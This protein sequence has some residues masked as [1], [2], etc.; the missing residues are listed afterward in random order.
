MTGWPGWGVTAAGAVL[1]L[2]ALRDIFHT[3]WHPSGRGGLSRRLMR[4]VWRAGRGRVPGPLTGPVAMVVVV[5]AW[6]TLITGGWALVYWPHLPAGFAFGSG[7]DPGPRAGA[8]DALYL[9]AVT[10]ATLGFGDIV[11]EAAWLRLVVPVQAMIGFALITAAVSWVLQV[12]PALSRR[13]A[14]AVRLSLLRRADGTG[15]V[16]GGGALAARLLTDLAWEVVQVRVDLSQYAE[17]Y[18][19][20]DATAETSLPAALGFALDLAALAG[21]TPDPDTRSAGRLLAEAVAAHLAVVDAGFVR[22]G[23]PPRA[24]LRRYAADTGPGRDPS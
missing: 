5:L 8:L 6:V 1:V 11:P 19:F 22:S 9:S 7:V 21:E 15:L 17:T 24:V 4:S 23:A 20:R 13:R 10:L 12:Y 3:I 14:L 2:V 16:A 18:W